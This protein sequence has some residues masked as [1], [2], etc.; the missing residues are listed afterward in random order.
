MCERGLHRAWLVWRRH[1]GVLRRQLCRAHGRSRRHLLCGR[2]DGCGDGCHRR[3]RSDWRSLLR[4]R[5][6]L[7]RRRH[8]RRHVS[9]PRRQYSWHGQVALLGGRHGGP[10]SHRGEERLHW[11]RRVARPSGWHSS[12]GR[13]RSGHR[14][15]EC[16]HWCWGVARLG[17]RDG[18]LCGHGGGWRGR[19]C[20]HNSRLSSSHGGQECL[21]HRRH[22]AGRRHHGL[23]SVGLRRREAR[24]RLERGGGRGQ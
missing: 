6:V 13:L 19:L 9:N 5:G 2:I 22:C 10:C 8:R 15:E 16:L 24:G 11:R 4:G 1:R 20:G 7:M 14:G 21:H 3:R 23:Q 18:G 12:D 17:G